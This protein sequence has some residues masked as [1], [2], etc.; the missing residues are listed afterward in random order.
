MAHDVI[1]VGAGPGG[2]AAATDLARAG[3]RILV[4]DEQPEAGGQIWRAAERAG[5]SLPPATWLGEDYARGVAVVGEARRQAGI[6]WRFGSSVWDIDCRADTIRLGVV[7]DGKAGTVEAAHVV[8]ATGAME[9]PV[10]FEGWT[11]PGVMGI[12]AAQTLLKDSGLLPPEGVVLAGSGPLLYLF[13]I[14]LLDAEVMPGAVLDSAPPGLSGG[15]LM[16]FLRAAPGNW[17]SLAKGLAWRR[18][19]ARAG[20]R[21]VAGVTSL[22]AVGGDRVEQV[23][24]G[25]DGTSHR[26]A[27]PLLLVH[28]GV[29][30]NTYLT[31]AAGCVHVWNE[32]QRSWRPDLDTDGQT[33]RRGLYVVGD[34]GGIMGADAAVLQGR[35]LA[36][37]LAGRLGLHSGEQDMAEAAEL[38]RLA[39]LRRFLDRQY[40][41]SRAFADPSDTTI[42]CRCE[43]VTAG[44]IRA[45]ANIGC[46]G[47]NQA[48]VFTRAGMG[49]CM[50]RQCG[51]AVASL[52]AASQGRTMVDIGQLSVRPPV[53]PITLAELAS[54]AETGAAD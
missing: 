52:L 17:R 42:I 44:D 6:D 33:S 11:L 22:K 1:I 24:Y 54:L 47:P 8:L 2:L 45:L 32:D 51:P 23:E 12:G 35:A 10:P 16:P 39:Q 34:G 26:I 14:Q 49:P 20:V 7:E 4:I 43:G 31:R 21:H 50:G 15:A 27:A 30:P 46:T 53:K 9:R 5:A 3:A 28:D 29:I 18:R 37:R 19:I 13:A 48:R 40:P 41:P 36:R 25:V 38:A